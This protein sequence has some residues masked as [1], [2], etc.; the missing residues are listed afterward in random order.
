M[1]YSSLNLLTSLVIS[2][3]PGYSTSKSTMP[4]LHRLWIVLTAL[5]FN[6]GKRWHVNAVSKSSVGTKTILSADKHS[7]YTRS[8]IFRPQTRRVGETIAC[9]WEIL[10]KLGTQCREKTF[11]YKSKYSVGRNI[12][13]F[14]KLR[15]QCTPD[16]SATSCVCATLRFHQHG[17]F[18]V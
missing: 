3:V 10:G 16:F 7:V 11:F 5:G 9:P 1:F 14:L 8:D 17:V 4:I 18:A 2:T 6:K 12:A 15:T 13:I